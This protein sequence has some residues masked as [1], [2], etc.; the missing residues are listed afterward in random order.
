MI[1]H[2]T[3]ESVIEQFALRKP[4]ARMLVNTPACFGAMG[5]TTNLFPSMTLG[6]GSTGHGITAD[7]VSPMNL[8]YIRKV[9]YGTKT[10][11]SLPLCECDAVSTSTTDRTFLS[12][13]EN[14]PLIAL[15]R[16]IAE[17][18]EGIDKTLIK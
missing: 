16:L 17:A 5:M 6:S 13:Q 12:T 3:D 9:G 10:V 18:F 2:S 8:I 15:Q 1:I 11:D 14:A 7:N 4:V